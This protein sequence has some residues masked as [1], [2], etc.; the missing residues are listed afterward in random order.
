MLIYWKCFRHS[1]RHRYVPDYFWLLMWAGHWSAF[2]PLQ[3]LRRW[4]CFSCVI[5][6]IFRIL[7]LFEASPLPYKGM[8]VTEGK[9]Q[10]C[11]S[12]QTCS[13]RDIF[14]TG[15]D[16]RYLSH[17]GL[18]VP[19]SQRP[20][21][22]QSL[23]EAHSSPYKQLS[24]I[25]AQSSDKWA[26]GVFEYVSKTTTLLIKTFPIIIFQSF[27]NPQLPLPSL[28]GTAVPQPLAVLSFFLS[29]WEMQES[30]P[31]KRVAQILLGL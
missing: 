29:T 28:R 8:Q 2:P 10:M 19:P 3:P 18:R 13:D 27:L 25:W 4:R 1:Q 24:I 30:F 6:M 21:C 12:P 23:L 16:K 7:S 15:G 11:K 26:P 14:V 9:S 20:G 22:L 31:L 5:H 17:P